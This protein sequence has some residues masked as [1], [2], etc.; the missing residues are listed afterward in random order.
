MTAPEFLDVSDIVEIHRRQLE[1]FGGRDGL[2]D[3]GL[4]ES[5]LD[6]HFAIRSSVL[7]DLDYSGSLWE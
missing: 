1:E 7:I 3:P 4:R 5:A 6:V 2:R